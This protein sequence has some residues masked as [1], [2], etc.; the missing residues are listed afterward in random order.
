MFSLAQVLAVNGKLDLDNKN[1]KNTHKCSWVVADVD[2]AQTIPLK[3][4]NYDNLITK[5]ILDKEDDFKN[6]INTN[7]MVCR[8]MFLI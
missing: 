6:F 8:L 5:A 4:V 1:F 7:S 3:C 2:E